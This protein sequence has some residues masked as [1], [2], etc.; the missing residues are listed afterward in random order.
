MLRGSTRLVVWMTIASLSAGELMLRADTRADAAP[1]HATVLHG[2]AA[3]GPPAE[4][5]PVV[6]SQAPLTPL[7][8]RSED[9]EVVS[10]RGGHSRSAAAL[11]PQALHPALFAD[12]LRCCFMSYDH[13]SPPPP[14]LR[15]RI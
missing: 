14:A 8:H 4:R 13:A 2:D 12:R 5:V 3:G 15:L 7:F 10:P 9:D 6:V 1:R 11:S